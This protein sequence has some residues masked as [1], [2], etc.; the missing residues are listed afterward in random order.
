MLPE[1]LSTPDRYSFLYLCKV[2]KFDGN[3]QKLAEKL[4]KWTK[5]A[6]LISGFDRLSWSELSSGQMPSE[7]YTF[8]FY[9]SKNKCEVP[10]GVIVLLSRQSIDDFPEYLEVLGEISIDNS[11]QI[12]GEIAEPFEVDEEFSDSLYGCLL[13]WES[14]NEVKAFPE[15]VKVVKVSSNCYLLTGKSLYAVDD[16]IENFFNTDEAEGITSACYLLFPE[17]EKVLNLEEMVAD[18]ERIHLDSEIKGIHC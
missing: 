4:V 11:P 1:F 7:L 12:E 17:K 13:V 3:S 14:S 10:E 2:Q 8:N 9:S 6:D 15:G 5:S 16:W 18:K